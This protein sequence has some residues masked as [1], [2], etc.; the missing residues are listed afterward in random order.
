MGK[1]C[2]IVDDDLEE[3]SWVWERYGMVEWCVDEGWIRLRRK[4]CFR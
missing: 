2:C 3:V 4:F 1:I